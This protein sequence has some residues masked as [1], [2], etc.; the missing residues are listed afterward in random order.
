[1]KK[2]IL[3]LAIAG[4]ITTVNAQSLSSND[5]PAAVSKAFTR[6]NP[7]VENVEWNQVGNNYYKA[8]FVSEDKKKSVTYSAKGK[9][10]ETESEI[11]VS[12]LPTET[13]KYINENYKSDFVKQSWK[14]TS[15]NGK[16]KYNV[17]LQTVELNFD[18]KGEFVPPV[19]G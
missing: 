16:V 17:K 18:S 14:L 11:S 15:S 19:N 3:I 10:M 5:V 6:A 9:L 2:L 13:L 7:K 1:M 12:A 8:N 4:I